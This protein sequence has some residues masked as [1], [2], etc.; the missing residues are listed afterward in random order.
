MNATQ[1][2]IDVTQAKALGFDA[3]AL[4]IISTEQWSLASIALLFQAAATI[5]F[6][7]FFSFDMLHFDSP[8]QFF[9]LVQQ[10][11]SSTAYYKYNTLP[12]VSM[13]IKFISSWGHSALYSS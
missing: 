7:L 13:Y 1:A 4:N 6:Y 10:Y 8:Q 3:F 12:F 9:P 5:G 2:V 11:T